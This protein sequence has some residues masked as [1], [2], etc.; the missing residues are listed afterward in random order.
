[1]TIVT[2]P[3]QPSKTGHT[4]IG[5]FSDENLSEAYTF[6]TMPAEN[7][8]LYAKWNINAYTISFDTK[9]GD[10]VTN[11]VQEYDSILTL[12]TSSKVGY[13]FVAWYMDDQ[14][15]IA[16]TLLKMPAEN[17]T[18]YAKWSINEYTIKFVSNGGS[19]IAAISQEYATIVTEPQQPTKNGH[20][21]AGWF[22]DESFNEPY[23]FN[24][25]PSANITLYAKWEAL[26]YSLT[27][28]V[29]QNSAVEK[30]FAGD[31]NGFAITTNNLVYAWGNNEFGQLGDGTKLSR[32][33]PIEIT[34]NF[35]DTVISL[36]IGTHFTVAL[37]AN[38]SVYTW[39]NN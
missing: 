36:A 17:I 15:T 14:L 34:N 19:E 26:Q 13:S 2:E 32:S 16:F 31:R 9:G 18:L 22:S 20:T 1:M 37:T 33:T 6:T 39:G 25:M 29:L 21:F 35:E 23:I 12:P 7:I 8:T 24:T 4:F 28:K 10:A 27:Y 30:L 11:I 3:Q 5:W 38:G